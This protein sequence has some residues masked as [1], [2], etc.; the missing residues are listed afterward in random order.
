MLPDVALPATWNASGHAVFVQVFHA[1]I[2]CV[3]LLAHEKMCYI[4][5][6]KRSLLSLCVNKQ[7]NKQK[8]RE[9]EMGENFDSSYS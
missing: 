3:S 1:T 8:L 2:V 7:I 5:R 6:P 4:P 9:F